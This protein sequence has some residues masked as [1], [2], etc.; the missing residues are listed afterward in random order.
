MAKLAPAGA[1]R[2]SRQSTARGPDGP[3]DEEE[4]GEREDG[5]EFCPNCGKAYEDFSDLGC[6]RCDRRHPDYRVLP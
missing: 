2:N 5:K 1:G 6:G 4:M 3:G